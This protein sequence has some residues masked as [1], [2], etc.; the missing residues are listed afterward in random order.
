[1]LPNS[2]PHYTHWTTFTG[3]ANYVCDKFLMSA[4]RANSNNRR[5]NTSRIEET[6]QAASTPKTLIEKEVTK[7]VK[8]A[9]TITN[10]TSSSLSLSLHLFISVH[11]I[12]RTS[13]QPTHLLETRVWKKKVEKIEDENSWAW[14]KVASYSRALLL[15]TYIHRIYQNHTILTSCVQSFT[16]STE[17]SYIYYSIIRSIH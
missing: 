17:L 6:P 3:I 12:E 1:M 5:G 7:Q 4:V 2:H 8:K 10:A 15:F 11:T 9:H 13:I 14:W 16:I